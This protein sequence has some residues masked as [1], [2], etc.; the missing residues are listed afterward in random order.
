MHGKKSE[1]NSNERT[2]VLYAKDY[3][4]KSIVVYIRKYFNAKKADATFSHESF[5]RSID[6]C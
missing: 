6:Y 5:I 3:L 1:L 2:V 4:R